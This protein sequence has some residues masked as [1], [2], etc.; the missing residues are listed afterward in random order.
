[1]PD[2]NRVMRE[3]SG[4]NVAPEV[5]DRELE[6]KDWTGDKQ[7]ATANEEGVAMT[8]TH[9][10]VVQYLRDY[11]M[12]NGRA[13]SG[14]EVATALDASFKDRGGSAFLQSLF[15]KGPVAQGSRIAGVPVP[16]YTEDSSFGSA[17]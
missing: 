17:M 12:Q 4:E 2:V 7:Q 16:P 6:I 14:R 3:T 1:M 13:Q 8:D 9:W 5:Q 15:P 11:Y 10:A